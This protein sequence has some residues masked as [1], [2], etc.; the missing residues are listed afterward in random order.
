[1]KD[2]VRKRAAFSALTGGAAAFGVTMFRLR[3]T[4][5][6]LEEEALQK[7]DRWWRLPAVW[8][9]P[10][11]REEL[12]EGVAFAAELLR[13]LTAEEVCKH[14]AREPVDK[15]IPPALFN[16]AIWA[17]R[18]ARSMHPSHPDMREDS[19]LGFVARMPRPGGHQSRVVLRTPSV[20]SKGVYV[21]SAFDGADGEA[22]A[23][24]T[25]KLN[26]VGAA[27]FEHQLWTTMHEHIWPAQLCL[28]VS[29]AL[30]S[31]VRGHIPGVSASLID[32]PRASQ[33]PQFVLALR[34]CAAAYC[35]AVNEHLCRWDWLP[36]WV[37]RA[38]CWVWA[39]GVMK[40]AKEFAEVL[41]QPQAFTAPA[42]DG[43]GDV[44]VLADGDD[45]IV[46]KIILF[47]RRYMRVEP[48]AGFERRPVC[49]KW[50][51][52]PTRKPKG[53]VANSQRKAFRNDEG[54]FVALTQHGVREVAAGRGPVFAR[55]LKEA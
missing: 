30:R 36:A 41:L 45:F 15:P 29:P 52:V 55:P 38:A 28:C 16:A 34:N 46:S 44:V 8:G 13:E 20:E 2:F 48:L 25:S 6:T 54:S 40:R 49:L 51:M 35:H 19:R 3:A 50:A 5:V 1:M 43:D 4:V 31:A 9:P 11:S 53:T 37:V 23:F 17:M 47:A 18:R 21:K 12:R 27:V 10:P 26:E 22:G 7:F 42:E 14:P 39:P 33:A 24:V 32:T